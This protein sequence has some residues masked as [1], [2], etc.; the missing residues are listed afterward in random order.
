MNTVIYSTDIEPITVL[1]LPLALLEK[2]AVEGQAKL[3][4]RGNNT[5]YGNQVCILKHTRLL[6]IEGEF[7]S[8]L[9]TEDE[10][11][12]MLAKPTWLPGQQGQVRFYIERIDSLKKQIKDD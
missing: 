3:L 11:A 4:I 8:V 10:T 5:K 6:T 9:T 2:A 1:D 12:A 7:V